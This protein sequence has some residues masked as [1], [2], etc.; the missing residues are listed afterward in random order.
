LKKLTICPSS[1][2][3]PKGSWPLLFEKENPPL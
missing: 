2:P 3:R 1:L